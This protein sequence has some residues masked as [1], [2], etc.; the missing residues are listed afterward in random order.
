MQ[1]L[2]DPHIKSMLKK[3][4]EQ[5]NFAQIKAGGNPQVVSASLDPARMWTS[6]LTDNMTAEIS[7]PRRRPWKFGL[8]A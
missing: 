1:G 8:C 5:L 3:I 2:F 4:R 6:L 7:N